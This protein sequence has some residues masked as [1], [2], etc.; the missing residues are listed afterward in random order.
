MQ[1][2]YLQDN[3]FCST[4]FR[5]NNRFNLT[6]RQDGFRVWTDTVWR[7]LGEKLLRSFHRHGD[8]LIGDL[9]LFIFKAQ[10]EFD[11]LTDFKR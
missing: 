9:A 4:Y 6:G 3:G 8:K 5:Q 1:M 10:S 11:L 7:L 2:A